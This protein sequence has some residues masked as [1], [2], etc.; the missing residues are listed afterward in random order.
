[1]VEATIEKSRRY[2]NG[3][4]RDMNNAVE[5]FPSNLVAKP[6]GF[7]A[8]EFFELDAAEQAARQPVAVKF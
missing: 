5:Q 7:A 6:F 3:S 2:Y 1:D 4:V 8:A